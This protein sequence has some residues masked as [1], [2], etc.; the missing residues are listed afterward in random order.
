[1]ITRLI[2]R[3]ATAAALASLLP[4]LAAAQ[5]APSPAESL[6]HAC[7]VPGTGTVYRIKERGLAAACAAGHVPFTWGESSRVGPS[8]TSGP[9]TTA[10]GGSGGGSATAV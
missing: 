1:M 9:G 5:P 4:A 3:F 6:F 2:S 10:A 7:Y 8:M